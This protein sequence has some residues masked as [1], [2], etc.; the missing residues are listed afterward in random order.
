M[1]AL[2]SYSLLLAF[3]FCLYSILAALIGHWKQKPLLQ[4]SAERAVIAACGL[5]VVAT[6]CLAVLL[7][8]DDFRLAYI[9][10]HSN[11]ALPVYFKFAALWSGQEGS[12]LWWSCLMSLFA[13]TA[14]SVNRR[15][16]AHLM[17]YA[18]AVLMGVLLFFLILNNFATNPFRL[19]TAETPRGP[20]VFSPPDGG[21]LNPLLQH[22]AMVIHPPMLYLG[23]VGFSVPFA[24]ALS[25]L[26]T[27]SKG[28][29]WIRITRHW[30]MIAWCFLTIG[31]LLGGRWAYAV[32]GWGGYWG[33]DPVENASLLPW[34]TGTAFLHSVMM[35]EK[36]GM[37]KV[38]N[39][40]LIF[41]TFL[42]CIFGTFLTRSG[43]L[44]SVHAFAQSAIGPYFAVF[45]SFLLF[46]CG[47][48]LLRRLDFLKSENQLDSLASRESSFL[49]NNLILL[50]SCFAVLW[51]TL[52]PLI[53]EAVQGVKISVGAPYFN[54]IQ[55]PIGLFLLFLTGVGPLFAWRRTSLESLQRN[56]T[57]P[58]IFG[59]VVA[60]AAF[61]FG[62]RNFYALV[63]IFLAF[64]VIGTIA[65]E[66]FRGARVIHQKEERNWAG[67]VIELTRR[68]TRRYGGYVIHFGVAL[69]FIGFVGSAFTIHEQAEVLPGDE[70]TVRNY[71]FVVQSLDQQ[72]TDN[73][74]A[75]QARIDVFRN[76]KFLATLTPERRFYKASGQPTTEVAI[77]PH[78]SKP[79]EIFQHPHADIYLVFAGMAEDNQRAVLQIYI[80]P[81]VLW[82]WVGGA[83]MVFGTGI[84]LVSS[85]PPQPGRP[86][87]KRKPAKERDEVPA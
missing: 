17:P 79:L 69:L 73:H 46:V 49:F 30:T 7:L 45:L 84:A 82:V 72:E 63:A 71:R 42:L 56:F 18:V 77:W 62:A 22:P 20:E 14:V 64:F 68:N 41:A 37:M 43:V 4:Q 48:V 47:F 60:I 51:G 32:L 59:G 35:Q 70:V 66:F 2:G 55:I 15:T 1:D 75:S 61:L 78:L 58:L 34:L 39:M 76:D 16:H 10:S 6:F 29:Q 83:V 52:F 19:L 50:A 38:W 65:L 85:R 25:A 5:V 67:A 57:R 9:A 3:C 28:E 80:N 87:R 33:W 21:G 54:K 27:R 13:A 36:R 86:T 12:L 11:R 31:V 26:I 23:F 8:R 44:S 40:G 81:L 74:I 24:F 53:S